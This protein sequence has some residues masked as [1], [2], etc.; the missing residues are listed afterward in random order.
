MVPAPP[1]D[2]QCRFLVVR[3]NCAAHIWCW[4][5][6]VVMMQSRPPSLSRR[7]STCC[8]RRP[9]FLAY[10]SGYDLR[11]V[12][13]CFSH[14][15]ESHLS[16]SGSRSSITRRASPSRL[17]S[18]RTILLNSA[19][20]MSMW[21]LAASGQNS[22]SLPVMRSSQRAPMAMIRSQWVTALLA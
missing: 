20:S 18:G 9:P 22:D 8:A 16:T 7:S 12:A 1:E 3:Q 2:I 11:Q 5:T 10:F 17:T 13:I 19:G 14:S 21:I 4:P 6:S 15:P